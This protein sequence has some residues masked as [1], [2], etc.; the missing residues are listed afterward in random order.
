MKLFWPAFRAV[1]LAACHVLSASLN[2]STKDKNAERKD[3]VAVYETKPPLE[4]VLRDGTRLREPQI[5]SWNEES[6]LIAH[7]SGQ[8]EIPYQEIIRSQNDRLWGLYR[9]AVHAES[10]SKVAGKTVFPI[11]MRKYTGRFLSK[12]RLGLG[13]IRIYVFPEGTL[14]TLPNASTPIAL[15]NLIAS[16]LTSPSGYFELNLPENTRF[17]ILAQSPVSDNP[18]NAQLE[19]LIYISDFSPTAPLIVD[20]KFLQFRREYFIPL[21]LSQDIAMPTMTATAPT[22]PSGQSHYGSGGGGAHILRKSDSVAVYY[23]TDREYLKRLF[24][25]NKYGAGRSEMS[26][27]ICY[28]SIPK[29]HRSGE[30]ETYKFWKF[31][32]RN[33]PEDHVSLLK[34]KPMDE[35]VFTSTMRERLKNTRAKKAFVFIHGY[36]VSFEDAARRTAQIYFD[37]QFDGLPIFYSWPSAGEFKFY[38]TDEANIEWSES[39]IKRFISRFLETTDANDVYLIAHSMGNRALARVISDICDKSPK[40]KAKLKEIILAAPDIDSDVF[41]R[42]LAPQL[43]AT[44]SNATSGKVTL[45]VSSEDVALKAS[46]KFHSYPRIGDS[47]GGIKPISGIEIIDASAVDSSF[48]GHSYFADNRNVLSDI[49]YMIRGARNASERFGLRPIDTTSGRYWE[50]K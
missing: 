5:L 41:R 32:F 33:N 35:E 37:L 19:W 8:K 39:N 27:G 38:P 48:L 21:P 25:K 22:S 31:E 6:A 3:S 2:A 29:S 36:N 13:G 18:T 40:A 20:D 42:D 43:T 45:Y 30:L 16:T 23:A 15:N 24:L 47:S 28:V 12:E 17:V 9:L 11:A 7:D 34:I 1:T 26:Y 49:Y 44:L 50:F 46:K 14:D 10:P 4:F